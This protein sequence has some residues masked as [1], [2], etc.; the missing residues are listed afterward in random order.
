MYTIEVTS[1]SV[2]RL[3]TSTNTQMAIDAFFNAVMSMRDELKRLGYEYSEAH[4][5]PYMLNYKA[6]V[7]GK[8]LEYG[9]ILR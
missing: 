8:P 6:I 1:N 3:Y 7:N 9:V 4:D 2:M 5:G